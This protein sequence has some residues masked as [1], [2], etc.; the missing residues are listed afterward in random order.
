MDDEL[1]VFVAEYA[2]IYV[3]QRTMQ[4]VGLRR[5]D[6]NSLPSYHILNSVPG[7][8]NKKIITNI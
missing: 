4:I 2:V 5:H 6:P 8:V 7:F 3:R 1:V